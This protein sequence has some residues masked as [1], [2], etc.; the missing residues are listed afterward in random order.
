VGWIDEESELLEEL[1]DWVRRNW[2]PDLSLGEWWERLAIDRWSFPHWP[3]AYLGRG[4]SMRFGAA[5]ATRLRETGVL[6]PPQGV[7][8]LWG[9]HTIIDHGTD[10]QRQRFLPP[11]ALGQE[12]WCQLFSEPEAGSDLAS[13][14]TRAERDGDGWVV[15]G[16]KIWVTSAD[17]SERALLLARTRTIP[18]R[19]RGLSYFIVDLRQPGFE[20]APIVQMDHHARFFT[21]SMSDVWVPADRL[22]G[23]L[24]EGWTIA[25]ATLAHERAAAAARRPTAVAAIPGSLAGLLSQPVGA[26]VGAE[27]DAR[28]ADR[29]VGSTS[30]RRLASEHGVADHPDVRRRLTDYYVL[31]KVHRWNR[32]R[33]AGDRQRGR[34]SGADASIAKLT[35]SELSRQSRDIGLSIMGAAGMLAAHDAPLDRRISEVTLT[36]PSTSIAGGTDEIQRNL[37]AERVLGLPR[38]REN[39]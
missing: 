10:H 38:E 16:E 32:E 14:R 28:P 6:G 5:V 25:K 30:L 21:V 34:Q 26:L 27:R 2:S 13:V 20:I 3:Q 9:A 29:A 36:S 37:L 33:A 1:D 15:N 18:Q 24:D 22:V 4:A 23:E 8:Q 31:T 17:V 12:N 35:M 19:R 7:G 11:L 39:S